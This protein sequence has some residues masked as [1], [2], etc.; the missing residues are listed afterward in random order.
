M[1]GIIG[2]AYTGT[3]PSGQVAPTNFYTLIAVMLFGNLGG[4]ASAMLRAS[5]PTSS[6][7]IP[8]L[9][10]ANRVTFMRIL[11]GGAS[12]VVVYLVLQSQLTGVF[13][14][15]VADAMKSL[16]T[17]TIYVVVFVAGFTERLVLRTVEII[18][19]KPPSTPAKEDQAARNDPSKNDKSE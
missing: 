7:R 12:A 10:S 13:N 19:G 14:Q 18:A 3:L 8:E 9:T 6:A 15:T 11:L 17:A 2:L 5:D 4:T 16:T 1:A